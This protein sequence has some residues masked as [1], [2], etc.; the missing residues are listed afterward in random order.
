MGKGWNIIFQL[1]SLLSSFY[2]MGIFILIQK[3]RSV[4]LFWIGNKVFYW[5]ITKKK[6][7]KTSIRP[8]DH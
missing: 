1:H 8:K 2:K 3:V 6:K 7:K 4:F 5:G